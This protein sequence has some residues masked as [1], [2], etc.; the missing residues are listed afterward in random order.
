MI[1]TKLYRPSV[2]PDQVFRLSLIDKLKAKQYLPLTLVVAPAGYGKSVTISQWL[3]QSSTPNAWISLDDELNS[4]RIFMDYLVTAIQQIFP[5]SLTEFKSML[6]SNDPPADDAMMSDLINELDAIDEEFILVLDDYYLIQENAVHDIVNTL[7]DYPP[8]N[9]HMVIITRKDPLLKINSLRAYDRIHEIRMKELS[10][11]KQETT[12]LFKKVLDVELKDETVMNLLGKTEGWAVGLRLACLSVS[13]SKDIDDILRNVHGDFRLFTNFMTEEILSH[14]P[15]AYRHM[16]LVTSLVENFSASLTEALIAP[17]NN[18]TTK[19]SGADFV[20]WLLKSN[21]FIIRL[22][23][24]N[25][26]FRY[27]HLFGELLRKQAVKLLSDEMIKDIHR[28][29]SQWFEEQD[30]ITETI[31]HAVISGDIERAV[32][33]IDKNRA[34]VIN[35]ERYYLF[36][37]W[38]RFIPDDVITQT[39]SLLLLQCWSRKSSQDIAGLIPLI[40]RLESLDMEMPLDTELRAELDAFRGILCFYNKELDKSMHF[41]HRSFENL[42]D[43]YD[44]AIAEPKFYYSWALFMKGQPAEAHAHIDRSIQQ[45]MAKGQHNGHF[46]LLGTRVFIYLTA[47]DLEQAMVSSNEIYRQTTGNSTRL[48]ENAWG[49]Y[50]I[51]LINYYQD[52]L[53][54]AS[55]LFEQV[56]EENYINNHRA[57]IDALSALV[58]IKERLGH[59]AQADAYLHRLKEFTKDLFI[60]AHRAASDSC[61][62]RLQLMRNSGAPIKKPQHLPVNMEEMLHWQESVLSAYPRWLLHSKN[63]SQLRFAVK[64]IEKL[65]AYSASINNSIRDIE[66]AILQAI[67]QHKLGAPDKAQKQLEF[68]LRKARPSRIIKFFI[69]APDELVDLLR[70][71]KG[72]EDLA[73]FAMKLLATYK[74]ARISNID[75]KKSGK[76]IAEQTSQWEPEISLTVREMEILRFVADGLRNKEIAAKMFV[77]IDTVKKHLY[78]TFQ[79]LHVKSR[80][81]MVA[82][83]R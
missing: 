68:A 83:A 38:V 52:H 55:N 6:E 27:H 70:E 65:Q 59:P 24:S 33:I 82:K 4:S 57:I 34:L 18:E 51:G 44:A 61:H 23:V 26:W 19:L 64:E 10:F 63:K 45:C 29:A 32:T 74:S 73:E 35:K 30:R 39:P 17:N 5:R 11:N 58:Y 9:M 28:R 36:E 78:N 13:D 60:P 41:C 56:I 77:S 72:D 81:Q 80:I 71:F 20:G 1:K 15:E 16:L 3:E 47:A 43:T 49:K 22:D 76:V 2:T 8:Q 14:Q 12:Q 48:F 54:E 42:P 67:A 53:E 40:E 75:K 25:H 69:E 50:Y 7:L 31:E 37:M 62:V 66:L 46:R 79:K 21:L